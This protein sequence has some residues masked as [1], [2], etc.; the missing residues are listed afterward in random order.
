MFGIA[1]LL[2]LFGNVIF[3][4]GILQEYEFLS[5][6]AITCIF[7]FLSIIFW[8]K[9]E[10]KISIK[11]IA[12]NI[13]EILFEYPYIFCFI[14][15]SLG[16]ML[17]GALGPELAFDS[18]WYH[19]TIP[20]IYLENGGISYIPGGLLYYSTMPKLG[21]MLYIPALALSGEVLVKI[22]HMTFALL[23]AIATYQLSRK[24]A[25]VFYSL[26]SVVI[27][28][29][30]IVFLWE[31][32]TAYIDLIRTFF[33][34][35]AL[36]GLIEYFNT[37]KSKWLIES[38]FLMGL[39]IETK[40]ISLATF[41]VLIILIAVFDRRGI[42]TFKKI[43]MYGVISLF[44]PLGWFVFSFLSTSN[45]FYPLFSVYNIHFEKDV[46]VFPSIFFDIFTIFIS[47]SD[48][49]SPFYLIIAPIYFMIRNKIPSKTNVIFLFCILALLVWTITPKTGGGRFLLP[50]LPAFSIASAVIL[51]TIKK[52]KNYYRVLIIV[53]IFVCVVAL[54]YRGLAVSKYMPAIFGKES[55]ESFLMSHL[56]F[57]FGDFY[58]ED[59]S[60]KKIVGD[61]NVLL[62]GFHNLYYVDFPFIDSS[63]VKKG[64][65]FEFIATQNTSLPKRFQY[66]NVIY[67]NDTTG[68]KLYTT[69]TRW[70]Y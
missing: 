67:S 16:L 44:V 25:S 63:W 27:L 51:E 50:Y 34:V 21:E 5:L 23:T 70:I 59:H 42:N 61:K 19:L 9:F 8:D 56:N 62:Y 6:L 4:F 68:V 52:Y 29:T 18:L 40:L 37:K 49:I 7:G 11:N 43:I 31:G 41:L 69:N 2:G 10:K 22:V 17:V 20:K 36:F 46:L 14:I 60:I 12:K 58:D 45:P 54:L 13:K 39:S 38:A 24:F 28:F 32:T 1:F 48:P 64:D 55:K 30:N 65:T 66:W 26:I 33:E 57:K 47:S 15:A 3:A 35:M 53:L